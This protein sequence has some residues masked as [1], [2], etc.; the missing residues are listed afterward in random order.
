VHTKTEDHRNEMQSC[1]ML[2]PPSRGCCCCCCCLE[3][4][5]FI[6]LNWDAPSLSLRRPIP[7]V[8]VVAS[9]LQSTSWLI[10]VTTLRIVYGRGYDS[11]VASDP[12]WT[13]QTEMRKFTVTARSSITHCANR[14]NC[15]LSGESKGG[16]P[17]MVPLPVIRRG[18]CGHIPLRSKPTWTYYAPSLLLIFKF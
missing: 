6:S 14:L 4:F 5:V 3:A 10:V 9:R 15:S 2:P 7:S 17:A 16:N 1:A 18:Q 11:C 13:T 8:L 12:Y